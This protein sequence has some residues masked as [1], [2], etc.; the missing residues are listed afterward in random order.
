MKSR[1]AMIAALGLSVALTACSASSAD[2]TPL[3]SGAEPPAAC[4]RPS[5][6]VVEISADQLKF[7]VPCMVAAA[8]EDFVVHFVNREAQ[9][10]DVAIY[11]DRSR[12]T[13]IT[14]GDQITGPN[15][16]IDYPV[17]ALDAGEYYY[18]C[19]IHPGTMNG[20]LYA[21]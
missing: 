18:L 7:D 20:A 3:P 15:K 8:G 4:A 13:E 10:H 9:P 5:E 16:T 2:W 12:E 17:D 11:A 1:T 6:G 14:L 19:T 21:R